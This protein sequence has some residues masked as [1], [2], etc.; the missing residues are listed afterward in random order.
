VGWFKVEDVMTEHPKCVGLTPFAWTLWLHAM[1]Y[2]SR[3]L[4]DGHIPQA[5]LPRLCAIKDADKAAA[6]L[7]DAG[8]WH[9]TED[10]WAVHDYLDHQRSRA[11][12]QADRADAAARKRRSRAMSRNGHDG[13][14]P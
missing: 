4:T 5:M 10:G 8:M 3:N 6:E 1:S 9:V 7:V 14:T 13:V 11:D 12:V 2:C